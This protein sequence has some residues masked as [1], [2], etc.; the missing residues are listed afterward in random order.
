MEIPESIKVG[1][2][3]YQVI[4]R[5]GVWREAGNHGESLHNLQE[6]RLEKLQSPEMLESAFIHEILHCVDRVYNNH[7]LAEETVDALAEGLYQVLS[8]MGITFTKSD[9]EPI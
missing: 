4:V 9:K 3:T 1:G 6:I 8:D 5:L 2:H 7:N